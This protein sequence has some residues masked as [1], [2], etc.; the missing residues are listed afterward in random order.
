MQARF[1]RYVNGLQLSSFPGGLLT[2]KRQLLAPVRRVLRNSSL[3]A[4]SGPCRRVSQVT[5]RTRRV[6]SRERGYLVPSR[7]RSEHASY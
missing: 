1:A 2:S 3:E 5:T 7:E 6:I 4:A